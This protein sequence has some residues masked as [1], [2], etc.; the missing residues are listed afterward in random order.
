MT[1]EDFLL[2]ADKVIQGPLDERALELEG[3][4][5]RGVADKVESILRRNAVAALFQT[6]NVL[7]SDTVDEAKAKRD[8][9]RAANA[10]LLQDLLASDN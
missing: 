6:A 2:L 1:G 10:K 8:A 4:L 7:P 3:K 9:A 5:P